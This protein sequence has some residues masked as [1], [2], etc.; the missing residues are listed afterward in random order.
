MFEQSSLF[1]IVQLSK[2]DISVYRIVIDRSVQKSI[3]ESFSSVIDDMHDGKSAQEFTASYKLEND[4]YFK[5]GN[6]IMPD[7]ILDAIRSPIGVMPY[8]IMHMNEKGDLVKFDDPKEDDGQYL[9]YPEIKAV[10]VGERIEEKHSEI[11]H[12][13]FQKIRREQHLTQNR[14]NLFFDK[15]SFH[16]DKRFGI[17]ITDFVDCYF[18]GAELEFNSFY[19]ARQIFD[20]SGYYRSATDDE[21]KSFTTNNKLSFDNANT[22]TNWANTY[23]RRKIAA[24]NDSGI[25]EQYT[26]NEIQQL[27]QTYAGADIKVNDNKVCIPDNKEEAVWLVS[28]LDEE[29]YRGPFSQDLIVANSKRRIKNKQDN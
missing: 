4:E 22:F 3:S 1:A 17:G 16:E 14:H 13:A 8:S 5:I 15:D 26:A 2:A 9:E 28:F 24:I 27:A 25:L 11:F 18:N 12:I 21:V 19:F 20:L 7:V 29:A 10:F 6:F 23:I